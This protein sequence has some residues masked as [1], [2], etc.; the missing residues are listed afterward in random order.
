M[1]EVLDNE[2]ICIFLYHIHHYIGRKKS[3]LT[4]PF[5]HIL[6]RHMEGKE[7]ICVL[8][9]ETLGEDIAVDVAKSL[10]FVNG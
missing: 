8:S 1:F 5:M 4:R 2:K 6:L 10:P 3:R 9:A 7:K